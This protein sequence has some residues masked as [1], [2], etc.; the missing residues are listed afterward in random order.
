MS[1][2][3]IVMVF[4]ALAGAGL[5]VAASMVERGSLTGAAGLAQIDS[6]RQRGRRQ[7]TLTADRRHGEE[8][9]RMRRI[10]S[11]LR[12]AMQRRG[13]N[14]RRRSGRTSGSPAALSRRSWRTRCWAHCSVLS[15]RS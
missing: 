1:P 13:L 11:G 2:L 7:A 8:S 9:E 15:C 14:L 4:G 5:I 10:G 12:E 3:V 6:Q